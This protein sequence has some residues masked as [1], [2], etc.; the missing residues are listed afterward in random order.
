MAVCVLNQPYKTWVECC[1]ED[2]R[3]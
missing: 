2:G 3:L 1:T